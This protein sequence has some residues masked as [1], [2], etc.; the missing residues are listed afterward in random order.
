LTSK[1][2]VFLTLSLT[3]LV[4][5]VVVGFLAFIDEFGLSDHVQAGQRRVWTY[6]RATK[7]MFSLN[8]I[9]KNFDGILIGSSSSDVM[10][11]TR[12]LHGAKVYNLSMNGANICEVA[13]AAIN[14]MDRGHMKHL[15]ICLDPYLTKDSMMKT[16]ELSPNLK[17]STYGSLFNIRFYAYKLY[18]MRHPE[19][20]PYRNSWWGQR[21]LDPAKEQQ[22]AAPLPE[23]SK[24]RIPIDPK[25]LECLAGVIHT[26]HQKGVRVYA[27]FHPKR[28]ADL[29]EDP[30]AHAEYAARL[31][32]LFSEQ[33]VVWDFNAP[34]YETI[35][36]DKAAFQDN[37]HLSEAGAE[38]VLKE[39]EKRMAASGP[40]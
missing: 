34:T 30:Q 1:R 13:P 12:T 2:F 4:A 10:L 7:Q 15:I 28:Y 31:R 11:D 18:Y 20:D 27:Y 22:A 6:E 17:K 23:Q 40:Q 8:Y 14:A 21:F 5:L 37:A 36:K 25:A 35:T 32:A 3:A 24:Q 33:D 16:S 19:L 29:Q 39:I 9:P 38:A 26:A